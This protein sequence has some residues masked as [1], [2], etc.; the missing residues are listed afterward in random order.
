MDLQSNLMLEAVFEIPWAGRSTAAAKKYN[1][2]ILLLP[3][4]RKLE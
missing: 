1:I 2:I 3:K 4:R